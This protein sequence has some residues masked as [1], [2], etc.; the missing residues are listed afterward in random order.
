MGKSKSKPKDKSVHSEHPLINPPTRT[1]TIKSEV[2]TQPL[3][4]TTPKQWSDLNDINLES[5]LKQTDQQQQKMKKIVYQEENA[6]ERERIKPL[7]VK[8][9]NDNGYLNKEEY[10]I[11]PYVMG[12]VFGNLP[13]DYTLQIK[14]DKNMLYLFGYIWRESY[15]RRNRHNK[16]TELNLGWEPIELKIDIDE[17]KHPEDIKALYTIPAK[18]PIEKKVDELKASFNTTNKLDFS[19]V[20][21]GKNNK[22]QQRKSI[23]T[24][25]ST[26][27]HKHHRKSFTLKNVK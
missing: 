13:V 22:K 24:R 3:S 8:Y 23:R 14:Y 2:N 5:F 19:K 18:S 4:Q 1:T 27:S 9:L 11:S 16:Y 7:L 20:N 25:A 15:S 6:R 26:K 21:G 10:R 17:L 12:N